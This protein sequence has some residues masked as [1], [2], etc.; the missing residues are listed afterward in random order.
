MS[1]QYRKKPVVIEAF[2]M[3]EARRM[4]NSEW[5][6]WLGEAWN[7]DRD[8]PGT[9]QRVNAAARLPDALEIVTLE[10]NHRIS[11][12]DWIIQGVQG[13]LYPCKPDIFEATYE[14]AQS[15]T[16]TDTPRSNDLSP[17]VFM[18]SGGPDLTAP[19]QVERFIA[20]Y[21]SGQQGCHM[22]AD[23]AQAFSATL[24]ALAAKLAEA[25]AERD[26]AHQKRMGAERACDMLDNKRVAAEAER[27]NAID[28]LNAWF[29]RRGLAHEAIDETVLN[30]ARGY[31]RTSRSGGMDKEQS[32]MIEGVIADM[33]R[34]SVFADLFARAALNKGGL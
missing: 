5:P 32:D 20:Q 6:A 14:P 33:A 21:E 10:G 12:G 7:G 13:E 18:G 17:V 15:Q 16:M 34:L 3:T 19:V 4:D 9:L 27:D 30:A 28:T 25:E 8:A 23:E 1:N 29:D 26:A 24:R 11:W 2:Q 22:D 31:L